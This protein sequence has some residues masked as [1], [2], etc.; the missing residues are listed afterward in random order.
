VT[1]KEFIETFNTF[2]PI[3][4]EVEIATL[5]CRGA[6]LKALPIQCTFLQRWHFKVPKILKSQALKNET[7]KSKVLYTPAF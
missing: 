5:Q 6:S 2:Q 4:A 3:T 1:E 7:L